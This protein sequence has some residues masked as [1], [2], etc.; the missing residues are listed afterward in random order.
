MVSARYPV[1][2]IGAVWG[3]RYRRGVASPASARNEV[4]VPNRHSRLA[5][6]WKTGTHDRHAR[7]RQ[8]VRTRRTER[9]VSA[10]SV[11]RPA[12]KGQSFMHASAM[13]Y[14]KR[15]FDIHAQARFRRVLDIG[16]LDINGSLRSVCPVHLAYTGID[17]S[18]GNGV[19]VVLSDPYVYPFPDGHFDMIVS[20]SCFEHDPLFWITFLEC[21]RVLAP[22]DRSPWCGV[23]PRSLDH[24]SRRNGAVPTDFAIR[25]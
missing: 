5:R 7:G 24:G 12:L 1:A 15:F 9:G 25:A 16:S 4:V 11:R 18:P 13:D 23:D 17:L 20:T 19:D 10:T 21:A 8:G 6:T 3:R 22:D 2:G 14:G